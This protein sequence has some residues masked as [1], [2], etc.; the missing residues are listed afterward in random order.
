[1]K[2]L[3]STLVE[4]DLTPWPTDCSQKFFFSDLPYSLSLLLH[5]PFSTYLL[6]YPQPQAHLE[7]ILLPRAAPRRPDLYLETRYYATLI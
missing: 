7:K 2:I 5:L 1:M 6:F 4:C 3:G